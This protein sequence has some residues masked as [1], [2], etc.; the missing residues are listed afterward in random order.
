MAKRGRLIFSAGL[1]LNIFGIG[2]PITLGVGMLM[3]VMVLPYL[4][5]P[6]QVLFD[7]G[8]ETARRVPRYRADLLK[9]HRASSAEPG[10]AGLRELV[11]RPHQP[12]F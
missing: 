11:I 1:Q 4:G 5:N 7:Q 2:F 8:V 10:V 12:G 3:I 6:F 9:A